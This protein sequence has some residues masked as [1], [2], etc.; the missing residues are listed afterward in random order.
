MY[1]Y[2]NKSGRISRTFHRFS[3]ILPAL[4]VLFVLSACSR[5]KI[6]VERV[7]ASDSASS[8]T[9]E[10]FTDKDSSDISHYDAPD[11]VETSGTDIIIPTSPAGQN[12]ITAERIKRTYSVDIKYGSEVR[13]SYAA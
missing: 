10:A 3:R 6:S 9:S 2:K 8:A 11:T 1:K 5:S 12:D 4:T 7:P 13:W